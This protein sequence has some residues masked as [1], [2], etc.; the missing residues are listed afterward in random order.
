MKFLFCT[1]FV[2]LFGSISFAQQLSLDEIRNYYKSFNYQKVI[3]LSKTLLSE[4]TLTK[5][6]IIEL[7]TMKAVSHYSL[8]DEASARESFIEILKLNKN[9]SLDPAFISPKIITLFENTK[10]DFKPGLPVIKRYPLPMPRN[11]P[12]E[13]QDI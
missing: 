6:E 11:I 13:I 7:E 10:K 1:V 8:N 2:F 9:Y 12:K 5:D 3:E 4:D